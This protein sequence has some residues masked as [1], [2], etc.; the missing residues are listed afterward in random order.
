MNTTRISTPYNLQTYQKR[1][2]KPN[3]HLG[4]HKTELKEKLSSLIKE[5]VQTLKLNSEDDLTDAHYRDIL[6]SLHNA[7]TNNGGT[8][9][10]I[11]NDAGIKTVS[12]YS[13]FS[14][15]RATGKIE[16]LKEYLEAGNVLEEGK[17]DSFLFMANQQAENVSSATLELKN[18]LGKLI[19]GRI[20]LS[21]GE[22]EIKLLHGK[23][24][25]EIKTIKTSY[26][27]YFFKD[28]QF[29]NMRNPAHCIVMNKED[30]L[31]IKNTIHSGAFGEDYCN[32]KDNLVAVW[33]HPADLLY[34]SGY[35]PEPVPVDVGTYGFCND[36]DG[37]NKPPVQGNATKMRIDTKDGDS[38]VSVHQFVGKT[39]VG[40]QFDLPGISTGNFFRDFN[41][42]QPEEMKKVQQ[43]I[44]NLKDLGIHAFLSN[45]SH[46][47]VIIYADQNKTLMTPKVLAERLSQNSKILDVISEAASENKDMSQWQ[48]AF[49]NVFSN[50]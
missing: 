9:H 50:K 48:R 40:V 6:D 47:A 46:H 7:R 4:D 2:N 35:N 15:Q 27:I 33:K 18:S 11:L 3:Q 37:W 10:R 20:A 12:K 49:V 36:T 41:N 1:L 8:F 21:N 13:W 31:R 45:A 25:G 38:V 26:P 24:K 39:D 16:A 17:K 34:I 19:S 22:H 29:G 30:F 42:P 28:A 23:D 5:K 43:M 32:L 14:N 44:K